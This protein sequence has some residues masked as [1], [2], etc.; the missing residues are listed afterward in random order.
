MTLICT[1]AFLAGASAA[2]RGQTVETSKPL[3]SL[4]DASI[5]KDQVIVHLGGK[6]WEIELANLPFLKSD[7]SPEDQAF[8]QS[9]TPELDSCG[10][11]PMILTS[12]LSPPRVYLRMSQ[13]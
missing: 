1:W 2:M 5:T 13:A 8:N 4:I 12:A 7:C 3:A 10:Y 9:V 6:D 11:A